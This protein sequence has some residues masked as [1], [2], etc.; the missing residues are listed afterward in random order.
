VETDNFELDFAARPLGKVQ[1]WN[2]TFVGSATQG[3]DE[4]DS[5]CLYYRRGAGAV[6]NNTLCLN[7]T[8]RGFGG[9]NF[10]SI[11]PHINSGEFT[12]DG[13]LMWDNGKT[14]TTPATNTLTGQ[15]LAAF[16]PFA[17]GAAGQGRNFVVEDP[18]LRRALERSDPDFR[19]TIGSPVFHPNAIQPPDDGFYDQWATWIGA[20]GDVDWTEEWATFAQEQD[21]KP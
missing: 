1:L 16:L 18:K 5:P 19:P 3:F 15:V 10:D 7:W 13:V 2:A 6:T 14:G 12:A 17:Q 9:A 4:T 8:T 21:L 11:E 20:F